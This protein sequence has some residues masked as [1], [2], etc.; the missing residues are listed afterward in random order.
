MQPTSIEALF[1]QIGQGQKEA[2]NQLFYHYY[3]RLVRFAV[4]YVKQQEPAEEIVSSLFVQ[5]WQKKDRLAAVRSPEVY[6]FVAA[7]NSCLNYLRRPQKTVP[8][9]D[10]QPGL[11]TGSEAGVAPAEYKELEAV[12]IAAVER[13]PEQRQLIFRLIREEGLKAKEVAAILSLSVRTVENQLYKAVK[14]LAATVSSYLGY[15]PREKRS[16]GAGTLTFLKADK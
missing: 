2:F 3:E 13:L 4:Q 9:G 8:L 10:R 5:L 16:R 12:V 1:R 11:A 15:H 7:R 14:S 6:L